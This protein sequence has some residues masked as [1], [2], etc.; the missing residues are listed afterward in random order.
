M[1]QIMADHTLHSSLLTQVVTPDLKLG[2]EGALI[3]VD[4]GAGRR[5]LGGSAMGQ[6]GAGALAWL[7]K[8]RS[9][10]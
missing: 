9:S 3:H 2:A 5:R 4:L 6:V 10:H 1:S 8:L 7:Y